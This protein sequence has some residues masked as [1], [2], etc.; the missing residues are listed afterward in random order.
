RYLA[1][2]YQTLN[3]ESA[4]VVAARGFYGHLV[5][6]GSLKPATEFRFHVPEAVMPL[7]EKQPYANV[8]LEVTRQVPPGESGP[9][10]IQVQRPDD[11]GLKASEAATLP[12]LSV[13]DQ[14]RSVTHK[15]PLTV[16][17]LPR[18]ER[19]G[20]PPPQGFL[21]EARCDGKTWHHLVTTPIVPNTQLVQ[22]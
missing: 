17:R 16:A 7:S 5:D 11:G 4:G 14:P 9:V 10:E 3:L 13:S 1:R 22:L 8:Q 2:A 12:A 18:A 20:V 6:K 21:V 15:A 19:A